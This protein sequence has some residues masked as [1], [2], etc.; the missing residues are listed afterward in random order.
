MGQ[1]LFGGRAL[2][3]LD[4][5]GANLNVL[6]SPWTNQWG[7]CA[8]DGGNAPLEQDIVL[9]REMIFVNGSS[10]TQ[11]LSQNQMVAPGT[12]YVDELAK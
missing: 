2:F 8:S 10:M 7:F 3:E 11:V 6:T 5:V 12:F 4:C 9:R 1:F